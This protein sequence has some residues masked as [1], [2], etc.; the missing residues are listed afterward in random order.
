M[1]ATPVPGQLQVHFS[2][3]TITLGGTSEIQAPSHHSGLQSQSDP[4]ADD[5][6]IGSGGNIIPDTSIS[7]IQVCF[8][9][10]FI[11]FFLS[12]IYYRMRSLI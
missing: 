4:Q 3:P 5:P 7:P 11:F 9:F 12:K 6:F 10:Y 1:P 8:V 2:S